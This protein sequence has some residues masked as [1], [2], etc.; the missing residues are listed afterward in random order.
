MTE[1]AKRRTFTAEYK[2]KIVREADACRGTGE[3]G[4]LCVGR[5]RRLTVQTQSKGPKKTAAK[6][7]I[8]Q[9]PSLDSGSAQPLPP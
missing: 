3:I 2:R 6:P 7:G 5:P 4:A 8:F 1:K 9:A